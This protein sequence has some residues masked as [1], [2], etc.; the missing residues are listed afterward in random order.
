M[1]IS[2]FKL[3]NYVSFY[4]E[5][6]EDIELGPGIHFIVG[7]NNS[8]KTALIDALRLIEPR[9]PHR[10]LDTIP[11]RGG[12]SE[13]P[14]DIEV[15]FEFAA[16]T[17][18][19]ILRTNGP[20]H[21]LGV[22]QMDGID[23]SHI[24]REVLD[25]LSEET[26]IRFFADPFRLKLG[27]SEHCLNVIPDR[28]S[29]FLEVTQGNGEQLFISDSGM[30]IGQSERKRSVW[31]T[32]FDNFVFSVYK[33]EAQ[34]PVEAHSPTRNELIL[35]FDASNL[36]QV[37]DTARRKRTLRYEQ[38]IDLV[39]RVFP[40]IL[41]IEID[42]LPEQNREGEYLEVYVGYV[43]LAEERYDLR[44]P[45]SGCGTGLAQVLAMLYVVVVSDD[46]RII[47]IDEPQSFLHPDA[48]RKLLEIFQLPDYRHHQYVLT[49]H[50][51]TALAS[52][53][54]K[55]ILLL[56]REH[57]T[58]NITLIDPKV[59]ADLEFALRTV[60]ARLSDVFGMDN[61]IWVEGQ[62]D[63]VCFPLILHAHGVPLFGTKILRLAHSGD[64]TDKKHGVTSV[65]LYRRLS[66]S[67]ALLPPALAFV[68]DADLESDLE[69][70]KAVFG[71]QVRFLC[72]QNYE[73]YLTDA[74]AITHVLKEDDPDHVDVYTQN[75][76]QA[77]IDQN[78]E[79]GEYYPKKPFDADK[80]IYCIDGA[81][82]L[83]NLFQQ[84]TETRVAYDK[85]S[86]TPRLTRII[87]DQE[88]DHFQEIV[89]LITGILEKDNQRETA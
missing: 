86:H 63:E 32:L 65:K 51:P 76:I 1:R 25:T 26:R 53:R 15:E 21:L 85:I 81:K 58:S 40:D 60:G 89:D 3:K 44:V 22:S 33:F 37:M 8:G 75:G 13:G 18:T 70:V 14:R 56:E 82:F 39:K 35:K 46:P 55:R 31:H 48:V 64:F 11:A 66:A 83:K 34:R 88:N 43:D 52:V 36:A 49:T 68:F 12:I 80:W 38:V 29:L 67:E 4:D 10:S 59:Q 62:T 20:T 54:E 42:K 61:I 2:K 19:K 47:L 28:D 27:E 79:N 77:W 87:L 74:S 5:D 57:M 78:H 7:K 72:R 69:Q 16:G 17:L 45:L 30:S 73:S 41:E 50:S 84:L 71:K 24:E 6:A 23:P 9:A